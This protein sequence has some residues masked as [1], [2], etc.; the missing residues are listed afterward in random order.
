MINGHGLLYVVLGLLG[1]TLLIS[2][3]MDRTEDER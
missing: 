3:V 2:K 1:L